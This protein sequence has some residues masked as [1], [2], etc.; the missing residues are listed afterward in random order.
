MT[1]LA[2]REMPTFTSF[3]DAEAVLRSKDMAMAFDDAAAPLV[4]DTLSTLE[5]DRHFERRRLMNVIFRKQ[6][7]EGY[8]LI[9]LLASLGKHLNRVRFDQPDAPEPRVDLLRLA[10][11]ALAPVTAAL[12]GLDGVESVEAAEKLRT[13]AELVRDGFSVRWT[14]PRDPADVMRLALEAMREYRQVFFVPSIC[15]LYTSPSPRDL[16]TSRMPSSA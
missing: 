2:S 13:I 5:R 1:I 4:H 16:S 3:A 7:L 12:A 6:A 9:V 10:K 15:L 11:N 8:E 14:A